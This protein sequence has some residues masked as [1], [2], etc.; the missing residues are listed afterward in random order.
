MIR[1][2]LVNEVLAA[3]EK[4]ISVPVSQTQKGAIY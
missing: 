2:G 1:W 3:F 4:R